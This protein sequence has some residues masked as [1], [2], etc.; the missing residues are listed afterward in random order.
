MKEQSPSLKYARPAGTGIASVLTV[1]CPLE[2]NRDA[3]GSR[4]RNDS[5]T[6]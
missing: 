3:T 2:A 6:I 5:T 4:T 1:P